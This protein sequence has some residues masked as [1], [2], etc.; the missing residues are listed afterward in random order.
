MYAQMILQEDEKST[1]L[2]PLD[3]G[4]FIAVLKKRA[5]KV[6]REINWIF[7]NYKTLNMEKYDHK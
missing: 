7:L 6:H 1:L 3:P 4:I 2:F 5:S